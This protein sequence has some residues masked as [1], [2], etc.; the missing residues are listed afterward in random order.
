MLTGITASDGI[1][2]AKAYIYKSEAIIISDHR[3]ENVE[4]ELIKLDHA[5]YETES[6]LKD[7]KN[8]TAKKIDEESSLIFDAHIQILL[9]PQFIAEVKSLISDSKYNASYAYNEVSVKYI[10]MFNQIDDEYLKARTADLKD[11]SSRVL[12]NL[13]GLASNDLSHINEP[14]ILLA[15]DLT[16]S[17][18]AQLNMDYVKG[19]ATIMG[20]RTSHSAIMARSLELPAILGIKGL[21][22]EVNH[23]DTLIMDSS[24]G[25]LIVNPN[26]ETFLFYQNKLMTEEREREELLKLK[27][28]KAV[29]ACG[30]DVELFANIGSLEDL[31]GV[32]KYGGDGIG[33]FRTEFIFM[34]HKDFPTEEEQFIIYKQVLDRM[35]NKTV[36]IRTLDI[37]GDKHLPYLKMDEE[38]NP[39]LGH[40]AI[41]LC[42]EKQEMFK[43]Q[44][45]AL[46]R[47]SIY[48]KLKIMFPMIATVAE[49][50]AAKNLFN[51]V[52]EEL[53]ESDYKVSSDIEVGIMVEIPAAAL[54][55]D[56][57]AK[58]VDFFSI[59]TNDLIQYTFAADRMNEKVSYLYQPFN[60]SLLKLIKMVIDA[61]HKEGKWTGMCGEMAG[62]ILAIP[63]LLGLGLDE[64]SM[65]ASGLLRAKRMI[66]QITITEAKKLVNQCF[67][68]ES[69][70]AVIALVK[71]HKF[72]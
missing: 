71:G 64:F 10:S 28:Q 40:R 45:R 44:L 17:D 49:F 33:L 58:E 62:D 12:R 36:V 24:S 25:G 23:G 72:S 16:P 27:H 37:G 7:L 32:K 59:G 15:E 69:N 1:A 55:A 66:S 14:V 30:K 50:R 34:E 68:Y 48:G 47:A 51:E 18:T 9:D 4:K 61:S 60:P 41:R 39:F 3:I 2:I 70:E 56:V 5:I 43:T 8:E 20:S 21:M 57:L 19:I 46:L 29:T 31:E 52:K 42:L 6:K 26:Q 22:K 67:D 63:L 38:L 13:L 53:L 11:V 54:A 65:S 35:D